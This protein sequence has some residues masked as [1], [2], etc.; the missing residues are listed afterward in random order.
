MC[1]DVASAYYTPRLYLVILFHVS[2]CSQCS[3]S[4]SGYNKVRLNPVCKDRKENFSTC[5]CSVKLFQLNFLLLSLDSF[6][7][8]SR[9]GVEEI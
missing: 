6:L 4:E 3:D 9:C 7:K 2:V 8:T 5:D 1:F